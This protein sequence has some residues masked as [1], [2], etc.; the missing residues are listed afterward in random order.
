MIFRAGRMDA[1]YKNVSWY[2]STFRKLALAKQSGSRD[3]GARSPPVNFV[4]ALVA[5]ASKGALSLGKEAQLIPFLANL[6]DLRQAV[7]SAQEKPPLL[8]APESF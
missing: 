4:V 7:Q 6:D 1:N 5:M 8:S 2:S 3:E